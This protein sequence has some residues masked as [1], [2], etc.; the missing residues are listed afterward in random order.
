MSE[1][2]VDWSVVLETLKGECFRRPEVLKPLWDRVLESAIMLCTGRFRRA[3]DKEIGGFRELPESDKKLEDQFQAN[4]NEAKRRLIEKCKEFGLDPR[5]F[6]AS[7][8]YETF[9]R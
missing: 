1:N 9:V 4:F 2:E 7:D 8:I 5:D 6:Q 3:W